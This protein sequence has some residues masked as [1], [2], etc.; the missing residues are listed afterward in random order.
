MKNNFEDK[1]IILKKTLIKEKWAFFTIFTYK[2]WKQSFF[3]SNIKKSKNIF[4]S[5]LS[6]WNEIFF[7]FTLRNKSLYIKD[8]KIIKFTKSIWYD[9]LTILSYILKLTNLITFENQ[10]NL[11]LYTILQDSLYS[12][13]ENKSLSRICL[14]FEIKLLTILWF[15]NKLNIYVDSDEKIDLSVNNLMSSN[16]W[17]II[18]LN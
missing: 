9:Q 5:Y 11:D 2:S 17:W 15:L 1:G 12:L 18:K 10:S 3:I 14:A 16:H 7:K 13:I 6:I 4:S 8:V